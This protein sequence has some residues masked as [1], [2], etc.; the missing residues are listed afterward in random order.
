MLPPVVSDAIASVRE[1]WSRSLLSAIGIMVGTLAVMLLI[2]IAQGVREE[3]TK[4]VG[5]LGA[6]NVIVVPGRIDTS[7][8]FGNSGNI[9]LSPLTEKDEAAVRSVTGV[10]NT[11]KWTF[12]GG[13]VAAEGGE[14]GQAFALAVDVSW[15]DMRPHEYSEGGGFSSPMAAEAIIGDAAKQSLFGNEGAVGRIVIINGF[16]FRVVGVTTESGS[17]GVFGGNPFSRI[18][19]I[20]FKAAVETVAKGRVQ[21]DRIFVETNP[22]ME[23]ARI[24]SAIKVAVLASQGGEETFSVLT[25]DELLQAIF[26]VLNILTYLVVGISAIALFVG[27]VGIMTVMLMNVNERRREI[28]IRKTVGAR[29]SHIFVHFLLE[30]VILTSGGGVLGL[31]ATWASILLIE[32]LTPIQASLTFPIVMLGFGL[33]IGVGCVFGLLP[34]L[35]AAGKDPVEAMRFE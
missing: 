3:V 25:H 29:R 35:R 9:G 14:P 30:S 32:A 17:G 24:K 11:A 27:G 26:K 1:N 16:R 10:M 21:I 15:F 19:Y 23:P 34:A 2:S 22:T 6:N 4:Q 18:L 31:V 20:P 13:T 28:G 33:S 5:S 7:S 8:P 12:V